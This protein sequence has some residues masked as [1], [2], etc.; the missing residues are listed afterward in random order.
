MNRTIEAV[1]RLSAKLGPMDALSTVQKKLGAVYQTS[2]AANR[3]QSAWV[4]TTKA[5]Y[6]DVMPM[7]TRYAGPA[8]I[9]YGA[10]KVG[11]AASTM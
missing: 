11:Q 4:R 8:A 7:L 6:A 2:E 3:R 9:A 5:M 1:L 10:Y